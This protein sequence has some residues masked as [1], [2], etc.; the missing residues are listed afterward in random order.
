[1]EKGKILT[2]EEIKKLR[3]D[4]EKTKSEQQIVRK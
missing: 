3:S 4:K 2:P 1:M